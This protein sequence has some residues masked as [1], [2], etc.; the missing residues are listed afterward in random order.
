MSVATKIATASGERCVR[1][2]GPS[3]WRA[4]I[5]RDELGDRDPSH[6]VL[7]FGQGERARRFLALAVGDQ[8]VT[9]DDLATLGQAQVGEAGVPQ[10]IEEA[11]REP[12][13]LEES[14]YAQR[15]LIDSLYELFSLGG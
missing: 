3:R 2:Q 9:E 6:R 15:P 10:L 4:V 5:A 14:G 8:A 1:H 12:V 11:C 7:G 13:E